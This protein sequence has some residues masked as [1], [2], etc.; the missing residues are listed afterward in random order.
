MHTVRQKMVAMVTAIIM[1][2]K[3]MTVHMVTATM[4]TATMPIKTMKATM[5]I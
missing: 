5:K 4:V 1:P 3:K 2:T